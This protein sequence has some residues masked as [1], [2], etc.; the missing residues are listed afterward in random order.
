MYVVVDIKGFQYK[1]EK[2]DKLRVPKFDL[3]VGEK[4]SL[5]DVLLVADSENISIGMPF[6][7]GAVVEATITQ[8]SK[9][10]KIIVF[11]KKKR[12]DYSVKKGHRQD[13]TEIVVDEIKLKKTGKKP[14][15]ALE[16]KTTEVIEP[17]DKLVVEEKISEEASVEKTSSEKPETE[18]KA[19]SEKVQLKT[20]AK[21]KTPEKAVPKKSVAEKATDTSAAE[22]KAPVKKVKKET[23]AKKKA[24]IK[25]SPEEDVKKKSAKE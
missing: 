19:A 1:I 23:A 20:A 2:G 13:F 24:S 9:Y 4:V 5:A 3:E 10:K 21:K 14:P 8:Q 12:K 17:V 6:V 18:K 25:A 15:K 7:E 22:K 11:K 16:E